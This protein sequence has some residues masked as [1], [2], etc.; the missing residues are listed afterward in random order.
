MRFSTYLKTVLGIAFAFLAVV[1]LVN[2]TVNP[3]GIY[4]TPVIEGVNDRYPTVS[5]FLRIHKTERL[6]QL[7]P[8]TIITGTSRALIG[9]DPRPEIFGEEAVVYNTGLTAARIYEQRCMLEFAQA[10]RPLKWVIITLD[11]FA[12]S[13]LGPENEQ[14][15]PQR[16]NPQA[17]HFPQNFRNRYNTLASLDTL[18]AVTKHFRYIR[19]PQKQSFI[20]PN[21]R[22]QNNSLYHRIKQNGAAPYF[23]NPPVPDGEKFTFS[24]GTDAADTPFRHIEAMLDLTRRGNIDTVLLFSPVHETMLA[25]LEEEGLQAAVELWKTRIA[26]IVQANGLRYNAA[27]YPLWDF[28]QRNSLTTEKVPK[29]GDREAVMRWFTDSSHYTPEAGDI[30]LKKILGLYGENDPYPDFGKKLL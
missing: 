25:G 3:L 18:V 5:Y 19:K 6:K 2:Y 26:A 15:E 9:L 27:P 21:G 12:F 23:K 28:F 24:Y 30:V 4:G 1:M 13:G 20:Q 14:F 8:D 7:R 10:I 29:D 22:M 17:L 16:C 11:F